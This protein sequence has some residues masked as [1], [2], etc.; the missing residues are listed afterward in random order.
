VLFISADVRKFDKAGAGDT[1]LVIRDALLLQLQRD[2]LRQQIIMTELARL[3][4]AMALCSPARHGID[5]ACVEQSKP[6]FFTSSEEY[7]PHHRWME[8]YSD[9]SEFRDLKKNDAKHVNVQL[10]P[11]N[12]AAEDQFSVCSRP[13]CSNGKAEENEAFDEQKLQES[14]EV[15]ICYPFFMFSSSLSFLLVCKFNV[16]SL[17]S[18]LVDV[19]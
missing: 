17:R 4:H 16:Y 11:V 8:H 18:Y 19:F 7:M 1:M 13:C 2:R 12:P 9:V 5:T 14:N 6:L 10:K 15:N 3:E